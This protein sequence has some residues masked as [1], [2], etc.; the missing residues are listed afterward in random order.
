MKV[1]AVIENV[2]SG[3][4]ILSLHKDQKVARENLDKLNKVRREYSIVN[5]IFLAL[6]FRGEVL[7]RE[8]AEAYFSGFSDVYE[9]MEFELENTNA[10]DSDVNMW[11]QAT[12]RLKNENP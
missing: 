11:I 3:Y 6:R 9:I 8:D 10:L 2:D 12:E 7:S 4:S 5:E 1:Y